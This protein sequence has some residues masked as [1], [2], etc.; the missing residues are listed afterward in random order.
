MCKK[1]INS[2]DVNETDE[3]MWTPLHVAMIFVSDAVCELFLKN[4]AGV[5]AKDSYMDD[6]IQLAYY[7]GR[8][9]LRKRMLCDLSYIG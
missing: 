6:P 5:H 3:K 4:G 8:F 9:E 7:Y 2:V 1:H